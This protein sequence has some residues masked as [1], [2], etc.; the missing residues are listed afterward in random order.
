[1]RSGNRSPWHA[2]MATYL[3]GRA[4]LD[5]ADALAAELE[6]KWG[7]GRLRLLVAADL[8]EKFDRQRAK[9]NA[10]IQ[11]GEVADLERESNRMIKA[12]IALDRAAE[13]AGA[14]KPPPDIWECPLSDGRVL[15][16]VKRFEDMPRVPRDGRHLEVIALDE[17]AR[18]FE[19]FPE[20]VKIKQTWPG[21]QVSAVRRNIDDPLDGLLND[22]VADL[23]EGA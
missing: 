5:G 12:W 9:L 6:A 23:W 19:G 7:V 3:A 11:R 18:L 10:A 21:A 15:A 8:R 13:A 4:H 2:S 16:L 20:I 14:I 17:V 22:E 1:M